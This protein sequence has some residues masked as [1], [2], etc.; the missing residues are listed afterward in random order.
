VAQII[1]RWLIQRNV[2]VIPKSVRRERIV[3]N[4]SVFDFELTQ[5]EMAGIS[6]LD[7]KTGLFMDHRDPATVKRLGSATLNI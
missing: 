5:E 2:V 1:L 6:T 4:F 3:E 7:T